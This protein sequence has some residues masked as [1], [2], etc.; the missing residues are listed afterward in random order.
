MKRE[1]KILSAFVLM[2]AVLL[3]SFYLVARNESK[4]QEQEDPQ[5]GKQVE[6][7]QAVPEVVILNE[8]MTAEEKA[9]LNLRP[10]GEYI[11][12]SREEDGSITSYKVVSLPENIVTGLD[13]MTD[14]EK[15]EKKLNLKAKFQVLER[16]SAG[17][18]M[19]YKVI[20]SD[21]DIVDVDNQPALDEQR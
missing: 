17:N 14:E 3:L 11:V 20:N 7:Q 9:T 4:V 10:D 18:V 21:N 15:T 16:D 2:I 5:Q 12:L 8:E 6:N 1:V 19:A 13:W